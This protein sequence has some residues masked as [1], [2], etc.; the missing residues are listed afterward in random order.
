[1]KICKKRCKEGWICKF[2][3]NS[4]VSFF[5]DKLWLPCGYRM[6]WERDFPSDLQS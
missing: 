1:M 2:C 3:F 5:C 4:V 6:E